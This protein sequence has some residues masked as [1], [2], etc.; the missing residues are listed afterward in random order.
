MSMFL[1]G[2]HTRAEEESG[3]DEL[4]RAA[5]VG[6]QRPD[7]RRAGRPRCSPTCS[8]GVLVARQPGR[9]P[10]RRRRTRSRSASASTAVRLGLHRHRAGRRPAHLQHPRDVRHRRRRHRLAYVLRAVGDVGNPALTLAVADRV[11][12]G[13]A[14]LLRPALVAAAAAPRLAA[15]AVAAAAYAVFARR[16]FGSGVARRPAGP[17]ARRPRPAQRLGLAWR[18]Q[19]GAVVGWAVGLFCS[20]WPTARSATTSATWSATPSATREMFAQG[21][22]GPRRR[23][24]RHRPAHAGA[25]RRA[26]FAISSALRPRAEEDDGRAEELLA[27][28]ASRAPLAARPLAVTVLGTCSSCWPSPGSASASATRWSPATAT[29]CCGWPRRRLP[30]VAPVLVLAR[31]AR[32]LY[33][34]APRLAPSSAWLPL[35]LAV[36]VLLFGE[37][38]RLPQWLQDL[39]PFEH[40]AAGA[41]RGLRAGAPFAGRRSASPRCWRRGTGRLHAARHRASVLCGHVAARA[42]VASRCPGGTGTSTVGVWRTVLGGQPG[43]GQAARGARPAT[44]RPSSATRGTSPTGGASADVVTAGIVGATPGLRAPAGRR[45]RR[46][47]RASRSSRS[48]SRTPPTAGCSSRTRWAGSPAPTSATQ[49]WLARDQLRDRL[50]RVE[51]RGGWPT[52]ARTTVADVADHLWRRRERAARRGSTRCRR[53][54]ST[55]T[56]RRPTCPAATGDDVVAIDWGTLGHGPGRRRPRLLRRSPRARSSSRCSTPTCSGC[57]TGLATR[58]EVALGARVDRG[59][60]RA[61]PRRV[62]A[63][64]GRR[65]RGRAGRRSTAT[66]PSRRTCGRCSGSSRRSRRCSRR[67]PPA[68]PQSS[69]AANVSQASSVPCS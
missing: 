13:D 1:V 2:R 41:G 67:E 31:L 40:L 34:V 39:S 49:P 18:L 3:R 43:R 45:S 22:A 63:G 33:G 7:D 56:R 15:A 27:T 10:A 58:D 6:R 46:T 4:L 30:Y 44:T 21:G 57:P 26:G 8:L 53:C 35:V 19:R 68:G 48:G 64:P 37:L 60:H 36:V 23:L 69:L 50:A 47:P 52:L 42:G 66:P 51:R 17:G 24:L 32:L 28:G 9:L 14:R 20:G 16:D 12:P 25:D 61:E 11:V 55:A 38:L 62:G 5:A 65:R 54:R 29:R 59:L